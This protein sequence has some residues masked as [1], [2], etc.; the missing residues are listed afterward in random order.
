GHD[1]EIAGLDG[2]AKIAKALQSRDVSFEYIL[3]EGL[4]I[5]KGFSDISSPIAAVGI[6]EKGYVTLRLTLSG[7]PGHSSLP[8]KHTAIGEMSRA[9]QELENHPFDA[10]L[11]STTRAMLDY[12]GPEM[13]YS[14]RILLANVWL[15]DPLVQ[16][17]LLR[18]PQTA[19]M[20]RTTSAATVI[21]GGMKENVLPSSVTAL[22]NFRIAEGDSIKKIIE[23]VRNTVRNDRIQISIHHGFGT[24]P[25]PVSPIDSR[26]FQLLQK[27]ISETH[28]GVVVAPSLLMGATDS[29]HYLVFT[30]NVYRFSPLQLSEDDFS[31]F[32]GANERI[33][34]RNYIE[35]IR[36]YIRLI[37]NSAFQ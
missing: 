13:P 3:D 7:T 26:A 35:M 34:V 20:M 11:N 9:I 37:E 18:I 28:S 10:N 23:H 5:T 4:F 16:T 29:R 1:E 32:H 24:E 36:F 27:T 33:S 6:A 22:V 17:I 21:E 25:S 8:P 19:A 14:R 31:R 15:F 30:K 2:A 12:L